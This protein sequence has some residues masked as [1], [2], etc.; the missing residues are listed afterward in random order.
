MTTPSIDGNAAAAGVYLTDARL[1]KIA[2]TA[3]M[4]GAISGDDAI[5]MIFEIRDL[6]GV[7]AGLIAQL[8][9]EAK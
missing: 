4:L 3:G 8:N 5:K 9:R 7:I 2:V 6:R 1:D